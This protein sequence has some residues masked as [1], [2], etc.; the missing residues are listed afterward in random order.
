[1][2]RGTLAVVATVALTVA[3][4]VPAAG[5]A[6]AAAPSNDDF[7]NATVISAL[8]FT[9]SLDTTEA[10]EAVDDPDCIGIG[11]TVWYRW[12]PSVS[13]HVAANTFGSDYDT[14]LSVYTGSRGSL[15][16]IA[17]D[18]DTVT[19]LQSQIDFAATAG[20]T[21]YL[22]VGSFASGPG[23]MLHFAIDV[24]TDEADLEVSKGDMPDP[25]A[26]GGQVTYEIVV[27]NLGP[28]TASG[29]TLTDTIPAGAA[30]VS[31]EEVDNPGACAEASGVVTCDLGDLTSSDVRTIDVVV[32]APSGSGSMSN[33]V[34]VGS[35]TP[36]P[37]EDNNNSTE[38]TDFA[39]GADLSVSQADTP[40]PV[41][42]GSNVAD[43]LTVANA[44][45]DGATG[46]V[47][48]DTLPAGT[49]FVAASASQ[50][51]CAPPSGGVV[52]CS[53]GAIASD[54]G[55]TVTITAKKPSTTTETTITNT[56]SI[57]GDQLDPSP[58]DNDSSET[59]TVAPP[60]GDPDE[61]NGFVTDSGGTVATGGGAAPTRTDTTTSA[62][63]V[64]PGFPG[65]VSITE[66]AGT[67][68]APPTVC[69]GQQADITA[70][71]TAAAT[72]LR[73]R[74]VFDS[75]VIPKRA[76]LTELVL[77]HD[78]V[79]VGRC[80]ATDGVANPDP[81]VLSVK[82]VKGDVEIIALSSSNGSWRGGR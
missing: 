79:L 21:Y 34:S 3:L 49:T 43:E 66:S 48:T 29:V 76:K 78:G 2:G 19:G 14:T 28:S 70:P 71:S 11:P 67:A 17:C 6:L 37:D 75:S 58:G 55:A 54:A 4:V 15:N 1:M 30:F 36:D 50:G 13:E 82:K 63:T 39:N 65:V 10:T 24:A 27:D 38:T 44:G 8:P 26:G 32:T 41:T 51:T 69:F 61:A 46:V 35:T 77:L 25:V 33:D 81:C 12:T 20:T 9:D 7:D 18:D 5:P 57:S 53:L 42:A 64:P 74:F 16:Q 62:V 47:I 80:V 59:T 52:T 31:A 23:G 68:C 56:A 45:P 72:P 73:L 40:D 22:M 60:A